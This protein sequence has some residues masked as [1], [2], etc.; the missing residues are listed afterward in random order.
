MGVFN[1]LCLDDTMDEWLTD[2]EEVNVP[3]AWPDDGWFGMSPHDLVCVFT[4]LTILLTLGDLTVDSG[5]R[6]PDIEPRR[7]VLVL[8]PSLDPLCIRHVGA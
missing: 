1:T 5:E 8:S 2:I 4:Y 6:D 3:N 7:D